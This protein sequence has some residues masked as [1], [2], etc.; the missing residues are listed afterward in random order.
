M[1]K[2]K[3]ARQHKHDKGPGCLLSL[4]SLLVIIPLFIWATRIIPLPD[5]PL[6]LDNILLFIVIDSVVGAVLRA[7][8][9][10]AI[11]ALIITLGFLTYGEI[12]GRYGFSDVYED[13][14]STVSAMLAQP[15]PSVNRI[16][17]ASVSFPFSD[18]DATTSRFEVDPGLVTLAQE[19]SLKHFRDYLA[20]YEDKESLVTL[21]KCLS[22]F[23]EFSGEWVLDTLPADGADSLWDSPA[24]PLSGSRYDYAVSL[25]A[26]V[27]AIGGRSALVEQDGEI[28]PMLYVGKRWQ[29]IRAIDL[30]RR[31]FFRE[32]A[33]KQRIWF[34]KDD[35]KRYWINLG[36][37]ADYPGARPLEGIGSFWE[38][39]A[40]HPA[41]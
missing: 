10:L 6:Y 31:K 35:D 21:I 2:Q 36:R 26:S 23:K 3:T 8:K 1:D 18:A 17:V 41:D 38:L 37:E 29:M 27:T 34:H 24:L 33:D 25:A 22:L 19:A 12:A 13:Y 39:P 30:I 14:R 40:F 5:W 28:Y 15:R 11:L 4:F 7:V 20:E 32:E 9:G 16:P